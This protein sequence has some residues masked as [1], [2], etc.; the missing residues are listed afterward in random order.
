MPY[1]P[2][3]VAYALSYDNDNSDYT[4]QRYANCPVI[5]RQMQ[6]IEP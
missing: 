4:H 6:G 5:E 3:A 2:N 1:C